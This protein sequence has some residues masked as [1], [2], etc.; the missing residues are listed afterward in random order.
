MSIKSS[1][2]FLPQKQEIKFP[3]RENKG[4]G[5]KVENFFANFATD[6]PATVNEF[7]SNEDLKKVPKHNLTSNFSRSFY[8][9]NRKSFR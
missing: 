3:H 9:E 1:Q 5:M 2:F 6:Y 7:I 4:R 8:P